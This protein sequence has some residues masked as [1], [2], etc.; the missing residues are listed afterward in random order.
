MVRIN[1]LLYKIVLGAIIAIPATGELCALER[2]EIDDA[3]TMSLQELLQV[4]ISVASTQSETI[5]KTPAVVSRFSRR[6]LEKMGIT[7]LEDI[8]SFVPGLTVQ[9]TAIGTKA[10]MARGLT[11]AFNQKVL[12]LLNGIPYWQQTHSDVPLLGIPME[13]VDRIEVIRGPGAVIYGTNASAGVINVITQEQVGSQVRLSFGANKEVAGSFY[14]RF[15]F[16][17]NAEVTLAGQF[18]ENDGFEG[19][20]D[21]RPVPGFYPPNT[22]TQ[23]DLTRKEED[24]SLMLTFDWQTNRLTFHQFESQASGLAAVA[25][26]INQSELIYRG[27]LAAYQGEWN[28]DSHRNQFSI[29]YNQFDLKIPT[30]NLFG[31]TTDGIQA[32]ADGGDKNYRHRV[33]Y[34]YEY[35]GWQDFTFLL[36]SELETR[37]WH[38]YQNLDAATGQVI[39]T[40]MERSSTGENSVFT[41]LD[42]SHGNNRFL[43]GGRYVDNE[44]AGSEFLPRFSWVY[45][46]DEFSSFKVLASSGFNSPNAIQQGINIPPNVIRGDPSLVAEKVS[47]LDI[48]YT[49]NKDNKL[50]VANIYL[51]EADDFIFRVSQDFQVVFANTEHFDRTGF[52]LDYQQ[53]DEATTFFANLAYH[54]QGNGQSEKDFSQMFAPQWLAN[55]G[56]NFHLSDKH[57]IGASWRYQSQRGVAEEQ[58]RVNFHYQYQ[59]DNWEWF[60]NVENLF[61]ENLNHPDV[62]D[63]NPARIVPG[64]DDEALWQVGFRW[65]FAKE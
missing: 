47:T 53:V 8:I 14:S 52:E 54:H 11:E 30:N 58:Q 15:E 46:M 37:R 24:Q 59:I 31:G 44:K 18:R 29:E 28:N 32:F 34:I 42:Y 19:F 3:M 21:N 23:A 1:K 9:D 51:L 38:D 48:A 25:S 41:Q 2:A 39:A 7:R 64:E 10:I 65:H 22:P 27:H 17:E 57:Q 56:V 63:F 50:L 40:A 26:V 20:F 6:D 12:F 35:I 60:V 43:I 62:Q 61:G 49:W 45:T 55:V 16:N 13:A 36:G 33:E 4:K 5:H